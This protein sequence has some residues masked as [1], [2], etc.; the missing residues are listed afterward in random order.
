MITDRI[1]FRFCIKKSRE[2]QNFL[3]KK[4]S[5]AKISEQKNFS[6]EKNRASKIL[7]AKIFRTKNFASKKSG[8]FSKN[9][10]A[11]PERS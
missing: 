3:R 5:N 9:F 1:L 4:F 7:G 8:M 2:Y 6:A 11:T 10:P